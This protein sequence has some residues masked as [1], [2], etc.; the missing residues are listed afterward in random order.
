MRVFYLA[1]LTTSD[2]LSLKSLTVLAIELDKVLI[3]Q[4]TGSLQSVDSSSI[5]TTPQNL[6]QGY[7]QA[8]ANDP[9]WA[10]A[11]KG[12]Q[13]AQEKI[14]Q[15]RALLLPTVGLSANANH[16]STNIQYT[17]SANVF[18]NDGKERFDTYSYTLNASQPIYRP[19]N[20]V[21]YAQSKIQAAYAD[22]Q[23]TAAQQ[24][25]AMRVSQAYFEVLIAQKKV[26]LIHIQK[27]ATTQQLKLAEANFKAGVATITDVNDAKA[28]LDLLLA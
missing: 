5:S 10:A 1:L 22:V 9:A 2:C 23:L 24:D 6:L 21:Q 12:N 19:Q 25:L 26:E 15:G 16:A 18:R 4:Q 7:H 14:I 28:K 13:A 27:Q 20:S 11:Q 17:G 3:T 8:Q